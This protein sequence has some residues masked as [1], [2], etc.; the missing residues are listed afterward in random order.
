MGMFFN[1]LKMLGTGINVMATLPFHLMKDASKQLTA[2][3]QAAAWEEEKTDILERAN[4]LCSKIIVTPEQ[5]MNEAPAMIG[6]EYQGEW[7]IYCCSMLTHALAN[8]SVLYPEKK[9]NALA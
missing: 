3:A 4:W 7:A 6:R 1:S 2:N 9:K 5:L 8:I